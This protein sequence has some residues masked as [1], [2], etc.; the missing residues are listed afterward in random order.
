MSF[1]DDEKRER[2]CFGIYF[3]ATAEQRNEVSRRKDM[4]GC[5]REWSVVDY[6]VKCG[7]FNATDPAGKELCERLADLDLRV[8]NALRK[9]IA[10]VTAEAPA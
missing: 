3:Q 7:R 2:E 9:I 10:E 4:I 6:Q 1:G 8:K 5:Y